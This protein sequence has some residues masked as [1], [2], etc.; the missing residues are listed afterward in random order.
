MRKYIPFFRG[1]YLFS[2][3]VILLLF[4]TYSLLEFQ[5]FNDGGTFSF[6]NPSESVNNAGVF[7]RLVHVT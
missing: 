6:T 4:I 3:T 2:I 7:E 1:F 5:L